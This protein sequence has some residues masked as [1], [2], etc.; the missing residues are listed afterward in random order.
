M[1]WSL[2]ITVSIATAV[3]T[4]LV[5]AQV[6]A[7]PTQQVETATPEQSQKWKGKSMYEIAAD[8]QIDFV[9]VCAD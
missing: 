9:W 6:G 3:V 5:V 2:L 7:Q 4:A 8:V 1:I